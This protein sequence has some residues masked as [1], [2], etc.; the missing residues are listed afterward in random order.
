MTN[1]SRTPWS[2][3]RAT[4]RPI[5]TT[6][7]PRASTSSASGSATSTPGSPRSARVG[8]GPCPTAR[9]SGW[10]RSSEPTDVGPDEAR[11]SSSSCLILPVFL[12]ILMGMLEF[13]SAFDHRT[14]MAYAVREGARVGATLGNGGSNPGHGRPDDPG[15]GPA[16]PDRPDPGRE[17]HLDRDLQGRLR[18]QAGR[19]RDQQLRPV[20]HPHRDRRLAGD[21]PGR[22][23]VGRLDRG[24]RPLRLPPDDA[25]RAAPRA[26]LRRQPAVHDDP[27][28]RRDG[29]APGADPVTT[30][31][32]RSGRL[33]ADDAATATS[34]RRDARS[35]RRAGQILVMFAHVDRP[36]VR[37]PGDRRRR[38]QHLERVAPRP[39]RGRGRRPGRRPVH[40][41]RLR[42]GIDE[43]RRRGHQERLRERQPGRRSRRPS[44]S[45][46][47]VAST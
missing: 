14:A 41:G 44:T 24:R 47:T 35:V 13:G 15:R 2:A 1:P 17:H 43:G 6:R 27:D 38:R 7:S 4:R 5:G 20:R 46:R 9:P 3:A 40:A 37:G 12:L 22:R 31:P 8:P 23:P 45:S 39:A 30:R 36:P 10:S 28:G 11:R 34:D 16:R 25:A 21:E 26:V 32:A 18:R 19:R 42:D 33:G 29:H